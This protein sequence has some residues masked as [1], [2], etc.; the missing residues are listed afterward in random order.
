MGW[1]LVLLTEQTVS[2][3]QPVT[4]SGGREERSCLGIKPALRKTEG[5]E[6]GERKKNR[7]THT[8]R[9]RENRLSFAVAQNSGSSHTWSRIY[10][11][12]WPVIWADNTHLVFSFLQSIRVE[13]L[14][15]ATEEVPMAYIF[16]WSWVRM[17]GNIWNNLEQQK[18]WQRK[19]PK[20]VSEYG[21][22]IHSSLGT[23]A[24]LLSSGYQLL[25]ATTQLSGLV[26]ASPHSLNQV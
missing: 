9:G 10:S 19:P 3:V 26:R 1:C 5:D 6:G 13:F 23:L 8:H 25:W 18:E 4:I 11:V 15:F 12:N 2:L 22:C 16:T 24:P 17:K 7:G 20:R 21:D 14:S